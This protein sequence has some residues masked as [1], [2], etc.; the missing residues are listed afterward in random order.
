M[1]A[2]CLIVDDEPLAQRVVEKYIEQMPML[3]LAGK[4]SCAIDAVPYLNGGGVDL[5]FLDINMPTLTGVDFLRS[6]R[7]PPLVIITTAYP[8]YAIEGFELDVVDYLL[9]PIPF[10]R[11]FKAVNKALDR[12]RLG[13]APVALA[14]M[15]VPEPLSATENA[16][17]AVK[18]DKRIYKIPHST[19]LFIEGL[20]DYVTIHTVKGK[21]TS[22][23]TMKRLEAELCRPDFLRIHKSYIIAAGR[24]EYIE[25]NAVKVGEE[26]IP[27]GKSYRD[28]VLPLLEG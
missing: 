12:L 6:L 27:I 19:I 3:T 28:E 14:A 11:F 10:E 21:I 2:R 7:N 15:P 5:V 24:V 8:E 23:D 22:H 20:G 9:K 1:N 18:A 4:C 25:G 13:A 17:L 26:L 16:V